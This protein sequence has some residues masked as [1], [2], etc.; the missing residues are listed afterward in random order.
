MPVRPYVHLALYINSAVAGGIFV[1]LST[2]EFYENRTKMSRTS[3]E[4]LRTIILLLAIGNI[5][6]VNKA[7]KTHCCLSMETVLCC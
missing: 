6:C 2:G 4:D 7:N 5:L 1:E 3:H